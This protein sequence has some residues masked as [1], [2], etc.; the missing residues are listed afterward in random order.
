MKS[1]KELT[2]DKTDGPLTFFKVIWASTR[3]FYAISWQK[4]VLREAELKEKTRHISIESPIEQTLRLP[5]EELIYA[6]DNFFP[7][8]VFM[9]PVGL[10]TVGVF[11]SMIFFVRN[12]NFLAKFLP[13]EKQKRTF[14]AIMSRGSLVT[15]AVVGSYFFTVFGTL[16]YFK[17]PQNLKYLEKIDEELVL[18]HTL[19]DEV[20]RDSL[21]GNALRYYRLSD[22]KIAQVNQWCEDAST[23]VHKGGYAYTLGK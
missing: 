11:A 9:I 2:D 3:A 20:A 7:S 5:S 21:V 6:R 16:K 1:L 19:T 18:R 4:N 23:E 15:G 17:V 22:D 13:K 12:K 8:P 14:G 10:A